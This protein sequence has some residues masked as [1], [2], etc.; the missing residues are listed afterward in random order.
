[1]ASGD[2]LFEE[3][4]TPPKPPVPK[5]KKLFAWLPSPKLSF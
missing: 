1:M 5:E 3:F 2:T 4:K